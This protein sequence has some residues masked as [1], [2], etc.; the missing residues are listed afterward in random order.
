MLKFATLFAGSAIVLALLLPQYVPFMQADRPAPAPAR[1]AARPPEAPAQVAVRR[2]LVG[3][4]SL[5]ADAGGQYSV[6]AL[7]AGQSVRMLVDTGA[8]MVVISAALAARIGLSFEAGKKWR[9]HTA[10]GESVAAEAMLPNIDLGGLYMAN[11]PALIAAP[12]A[13]EVNLLGASFL[14]RLTSVEQRNGVLML[15]Q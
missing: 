14:K 2:D 10:N 15:R 12:E 1:A 5:A 3:E 7:V 11:V 8:T 6:D 13:G 4:K 9:L